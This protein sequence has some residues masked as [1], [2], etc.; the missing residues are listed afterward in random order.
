MPPRDW[1]EEDESEDEIIVGDGYELSI[2][3][4]EES[5]DVSPAILQR[6]LD[7]CRD[8]SVAYICMRNG[9]GTAYINGTSWYE[10]NFEIDGDTITEMYCD[11]PYPGLCKHLLAVALTI[12]A[13]A[14][15]GKLRPEED[16]VAIDSNRFWNMVARTTKKVTL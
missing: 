3:A 1:N 15:N 9:A 14:E 8:G 11:C 5:E 10:V 12:R 4:P 16:F 13:L 2:L 6:A 7:Y